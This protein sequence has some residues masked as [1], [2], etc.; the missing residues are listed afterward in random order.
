MELILKRT[1]KAKDFTE[2]ELY[3][4]T[5]NVPQLICATLEPTW[6]DLRHGEAKVM[7]QTAVPEG[8]YQI[9]MRHSP[10]FKRLMPYLCEVPNFSQVMIHPGNTVAD[11]RGCILVGEKNRSGVLINSRR[12]FTEFLEV[13][14]RAQ[15]ISLLI[16]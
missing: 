9:E 13:T 5:G 3:L 8:R 10:T 7:G 12:C 2:G 4:M 1:N 6:R 15:I 11:T 16:V 14:S